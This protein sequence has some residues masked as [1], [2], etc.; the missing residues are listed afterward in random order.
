MPSEY[1]VRAWPAPVSM[2]RRWRGK[3]SASAPA[4]TPMKN[5][6]SMRMPSATPTMNG[7]FVSSS[8]SQP[9]TTFS[10]IM[11]TEFSSTEAPR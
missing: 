6:G 4:G 2:S 1:V 3:R 10:P 11:P 7:E 8:V 9:S 5:I